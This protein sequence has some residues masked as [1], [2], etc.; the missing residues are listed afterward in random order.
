[1]E[2]PLLHK[3]PIHVE[4]VFVRKVHISNCRKTTTNTDQNTEHYKN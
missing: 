2:T 1:M 4:N 3:F